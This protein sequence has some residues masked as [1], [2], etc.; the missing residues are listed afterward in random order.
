MI[1]IN[2]SVATNFSD[3]FGLQF[4]QYGDGLSVIDQN[5]ADLL[6]FNDEPVDGNGARNNETWSLNQIYAGLPLKDEPP[7][8]FDDNRFDLLRPF[9]DNDAEVGA[10][11]TAST[12]ND[13][14]SM[15]QRNNEMY[16]ILRNVESPTV[17]LTRVIEW[18]N[19][20]ANATKN[21]T[22]T[23]TGTGTST[24]AKVSAD[25]SD[26]NK[27]NNTAANDIKSEPMPT[28]S[29]DATRKVHVKSESSDGDDEIY[30]DSKNS[31]SGFSSNVE[32]TEEVNI[33]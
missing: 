22:E 6:D 27:M 32:L 26:N 10:L 7:E 12:S 21:E 16:G 30:D 13:F 8:L 14:N 11:S 23:E 28:E 20:F 9:S 18:S 5:L 3:S 24:E 2:A 15:N 33:N 17:N 25:S 31:T 4:D 1:D 19:Y 29:N